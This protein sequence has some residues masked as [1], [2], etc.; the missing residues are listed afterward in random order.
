MR[1]SLPLLLPV[2]ALLNSGCYVFSSFQDA[3]L[4]SPGD[5]QITPIVGKV[6]YSWEGED[7]E[8]AS[9]NLGLAL[10]L[11][12][13]DKMNFRLRVER[14]DCG[15]GLVINYLG[16]GPK[17]GSPAGTIALDLPVCMFF[18]EDINEDE[19]VHIQ[20]TLLLT[21]PVASW[22]D[23]NVALKYAYF[24]DTDS[25]PYVAGS[26]GFGLGKREDLAHFRP[27]ISYMKILGEDVSYLNYGI[28][29]SFDLRRRH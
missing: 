18:G 3:R 5:L 8:D 15:E 29:V 22:V 13:T 10:A 7:S 11:G 19:S 28:G 1:S 24:F 21:H 14:M 25:D 16:V 17:F 2:V 23:A 4:L 26:F 9:D 6:T 20:P 27:E 12:A